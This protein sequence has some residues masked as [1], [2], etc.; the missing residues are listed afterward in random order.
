MDRFAGQSILIRFLFSCDGGGYQQTTD[1]FGW[2][3]DQITVTNVELGGGGGVP[4]P[5]APSIT[6]QPQSQSVTEGANVTLSVA[7]T[8]TA[9]LV[10]Q[11]SK[12]GAPI[13][14]ANAATLTLPNILTTGAGSYTVRVSNSAGSVAS[15]GASV[16]VSAKT[17]AP[18]ITQQPQS[19]TVEEGSNASLTAGVA[20]TAPL[21]LQWIKNGVPVAGANSATINLGNAQLVDAGSYSLA[22]SNSA[23]SATS[24]AA[25]LTVAAKATVDAAGVN[26]A[27]AAQGC[28]VV[29]SSTYNAGFY[30]AGFAPEGVINGDRSGR[31]WG[32]GGGWNDATSNAFPDWIEL[33][34]AGAKSVSK[35]D[36]FSVQDNYAA[37]AEPTPSMT[38]SLY[39]LRD[40][41]VQYWTGNAWQTVTGGAIRGNNLVWRQVT[42]TPVTTSRIRVL[43]T[44]AVDG[45]TRVAEIEAYS[46]TQA[47]G[48]VNVA[49]GSTVVAS[50][51]YAAG[52]AP[53]GVINGDRS[54][55]FVGT[56]RRLE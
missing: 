29:A 11:W 7:A 36:I 3:I 46:P 40:F 9:P 6:Q 24:V 2:F 17:V 34:F 22:A 39:G 41:D 33:N 12:D 28:T 21:N 51:T 37:P 30:S 43:I 44:Q 4:V 52:F 1:L 56:R 19:Q 42:F 25:A 16:T 13:S 18:T 31:L 55:A 38:F 14:E 8:G 23:G 49:Q 32:Q 26:V 10:Y 47:V 48:G 45:W 20:G 50:S 27:S 35:V 5:S 53:E 54:G 15:N